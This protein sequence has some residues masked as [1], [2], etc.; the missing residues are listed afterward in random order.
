MKYLNAAKI[1]I[2]KLINLQESGL[3]R[4]SLTSEVWHKRNKKAAN[5]LFGIKSTWEETKL[6]L[7]AAFE[8]NMICG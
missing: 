6:W 4:K 8:V 1:E 3:N 7:S 2:N 5:Y